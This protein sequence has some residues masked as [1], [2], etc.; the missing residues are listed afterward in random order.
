MR[1]IVDS[2]DLWVE[3]TI[4]RGQI[5]YLNNRE[6]AH[7]RTDFRDAAEPHRAPPAPRL[8]A[9]GRSPHLPSVNHPRQ[10]AST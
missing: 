1:A 9:R 3:F 10:G 6:F 5:Q 4:E 2:P 7:S 8:D